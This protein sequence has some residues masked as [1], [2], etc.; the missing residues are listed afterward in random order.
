MITIVVLIILA[1][2]AINLSMGENGLLNRAKFAKE[3][4][5]NAEAKEQT[6]IDE[7]TNELTANV[8]ASRDYESEISSLTAK[9]EELE[10]KDS[11]SLT[12]KVIGKWVDGNPL[13]QKTINC[14]AMPNADTKLINFNITNL[15]KIVA[16]DA[17]GID[18]TA[19][20]N[21][22]PIPYV[23]G[24][25][26][27]VQLFISNT[28]IRIITASDRSGYNAYVTLKYT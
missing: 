5:A 20:K 15:D 12:E 7:L 22:L 8:N 11:Y 25:S 21:T 6:D 19:N 16:Y 28:Q 26:M 10:N 24:S 27:Q 9:L 23:A 17:I 3:K 13:Y 1:V 4:Y 18:T 14:G 2:V